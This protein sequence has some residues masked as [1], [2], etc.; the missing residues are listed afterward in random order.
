MMLRAKGFKQ[1][2]VKNDVKNGNLSSRQTNA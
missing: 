2:N 1:N